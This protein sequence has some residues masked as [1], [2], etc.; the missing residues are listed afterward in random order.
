MGSNFWRNK[1]VLITGYEGFLGSWLTRVLLE[2]KAKITGLD[3]LTHRRETLLTKKDLAQIKVI[4]GSVENHKLLSKIVKNNKIEFIFHL[5][6]KSLVGYCFKN[7]LKAFSV[8]IKGTWS[9]LE[10]CR[11]IDYINGIIIASS[12]KAYGSHENLPYKE[13][14][15]LLG[16]NPYDVSKSCADLLAQSYFCAYKLPVCVTRCGNIYGPGDYNFS[17]IIPDTIRAIFKNET[18]KIRSD[19]SFIR[20]YVYIEDIVNAYLLIG[21]KMAKL[22]LYGETFNFSN[23]TPISVLNLVRTI[24]E[25]VGKKPYYKVLN[26]ADCEIVNQYLCAKKA[27]RVLGFKSNYTLNEGLKKTVSWYEKLFSVV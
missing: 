26:K 4:K 14:F 6:A 25:I 18:L 21:E 9:I 22:R 8:N 27:R 19:G 13:D 2:H 5:A 1:R 23:E 17:R 24:Y 15:S 7:P 11:G 10:A 16:R 20:D 12:D 3:I